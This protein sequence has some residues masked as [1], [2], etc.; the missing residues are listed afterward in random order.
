MSLSLSLSSIVRA[1][2]TARHRRRFLPTFC[3]I[4][5]AFDA[6]PLSRPVPPSSS[7]APVW[8]R[9]I[10]LS[11]YDS[12]YRGTEL[13]DLIVAAGPRVRRAVCPEGRLCIRMTKAPKVEVNSA[14]S[15]CCRPL[16]FSPP[17]PSHSFCP[18]MPLLGPCLNFERNFRYAH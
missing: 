10:A 3:S 4:R 5:H 1:R 12:Y 18:T 6:H 2:P 15:L 7:L 11:Y 13:Y 8:L 9:V 14:T 16:S 17:P